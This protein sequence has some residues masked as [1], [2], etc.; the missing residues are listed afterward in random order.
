MGAVRV[1]VVARGE[2]ACHPN[3]EGHAGREGAS[4]KFINP[5]SEIIKFLQSI[6]T[7]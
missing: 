5:I 7:V 1:Q 6:A 3:Q 4:L 2:G